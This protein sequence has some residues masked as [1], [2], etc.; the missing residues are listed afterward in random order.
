MQTAEG[1]LDEIITSLDRAAKI[2]VQ[3]KPLPQPRG[4]PPR[5]GNSSRLKQGALG[6]GE[7]LK[8]QDAYL[9][10]GTEWG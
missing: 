8:N 6:L 3:G 1:S 5:G 9:I 7:S 4:K 2:D 10:Q